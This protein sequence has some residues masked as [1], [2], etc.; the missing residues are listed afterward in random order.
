MPQCIT[1]LAADLRRLYYR[2]RLAGC[3]ENA[4]RNERKDI[5]SYVFVNILNTS[6]LFFDSFE[7]F[8]LHELLWF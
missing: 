2:A 7:L 3:V 6:S 5:V 1:A 8:K 4:I